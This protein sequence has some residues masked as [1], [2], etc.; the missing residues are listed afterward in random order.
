[1]SRILGDCGVADEFAF[2]SS[3]RSSSIF[4]LQKSRHLKVSYKGVEKHRNRVRGSS[5]GLCFST[6]WKCGS[7]P[8]RCRRGWGL[9][10]PPRDMF[11]S[12][13]ILF[14]FC[15]FRAAPGAHGGSQAKGHIGVQLPSCPTATATPDPQ[16]PEPGGGPKP[17]PR[18][19]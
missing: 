10:T 5:R 2:C 9:L 17:H 6:T 7:G 14:C 8:R 16:P 13:D 3:L 19:Y 11:I 18:T 15:L 12:H 1:M 4:I